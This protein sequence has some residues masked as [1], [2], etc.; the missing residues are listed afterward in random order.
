MQNSG[1][2][3]GSG[4]WKALKAFRVLLLACSSYTLAGMQG[5]DENE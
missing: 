5:V 4:K 3:R 2:G 1:I